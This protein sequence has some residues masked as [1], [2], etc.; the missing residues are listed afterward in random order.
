[1]DAAGK[2]QSGHSCS[3]PTPSCVSILGE[4]VHLVG[5]A[6]GHSGIAC[7]R[8]RNEVKGAPDARCQGPG[9][10]NP[11]R[12]WLLVRRRHRRRKYSIHPSPLRSRASPGSSPPWLWWRVPG[13]WPSVPVT[14][15]R[16]PGF[17][18]PWGAADLERVEM[19]LSLVYALGA[20]AVCGIGPTSC[21]MAHTSRARCDSRPASARRLSTCQT[22]FVIT[23]RI[24][25]GPFVG[26]ML[27]C[28]PLHAGSYLNLRRTKC[29]REGR[30]VEFDRGF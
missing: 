23:F 6:S 9:Q 22:C 28:S 19:A 24:V 16:P 12:A 26:L 11:W 13:I 2:P 21:C 7:K 18:S 5:P 10:L 15:R 17:Q 25:V 3:R 29:F 4:G 1:M 27:S 8:W 14:L 20:L 30:V